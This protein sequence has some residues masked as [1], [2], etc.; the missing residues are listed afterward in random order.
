MMAAHHHQFYLEVV[1]DFSISFSLTLQQRESAKLLVIKLVRHYRPGQTVQ[2]VYKPAALIHA[3]LERVASLDTFLNFFLSYIYQDLCSTEGPVMD[4]DITY[5][6]SYFDDWALWEPEQINNLNKA[7]ENF[8]EFVVDNFLLPR[9]STTRSYLYKQSNSQSVIPVRATSVKTLQ[10][11]PTSLSSLQSSTPTGIK[12][13]ISVL[14]QGCLI[15]DRHRCVISRKFDRATARNRFTE[16]GEFCADDDG[17]LLKDEPSDQFQYLEVTYILPHSVTTV[18]CEET[19]LSDSKKF[20]LRILDMFN[21]G[22]GDLIHGPKL[23]GPM[24]ALTLIF[25]YH[26][27]FGE[28]RI[29]FELT[30]IPY[31]YR[32]DS[33]EQGLFLRDP[34]FPV[35][36]TLP[37]SPASSIDPPSP[38]LL[39]VHRAIAIISGI[40]RK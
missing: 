19:E 28:F 8:A 2:K 23:D 36:R 32:I 1:L 17:N 34:L 7:I 33:T 10:S 25:D 9:V 22:I 15:R 6:L 35:T 13:R 14:R 3:I 18:S 40:W 16:N 27:L 24:N 39:E 30:G 26:R 20:V 11:T 38:R 37:L 12:Q 4:F 5:A 31:Q 29:Y 21:P